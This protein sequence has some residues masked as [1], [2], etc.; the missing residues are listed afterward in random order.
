MYCVMCACRAASIIFHQLDVSEIDSASAAG[1]A[2]IARSTA[3]V[4][5]PVRKFSITITITQLSGHSTAQEEAHGTHL[6]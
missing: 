4:S 6:V 2:S 1:D 5:A 3:L